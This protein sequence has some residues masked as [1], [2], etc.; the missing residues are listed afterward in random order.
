MHRNCKKENIKVILARTVS[1]H[2]RK[3]IILFF[4]LANLIRWST[5]KRWI[6]VKT[7]SSYLHFRIT[8]KL[9]KT[10][11][12]MKLYLCV[13]HWFTPKV[14]RITMFFFF[15]K[16]RKTFANEANV[17]LSSI[18]KSTLSTVF[19]FALVVFDERWWFSRY[20]LYEL[21]LAKN[22]YPVKLLLPPT[23][24]VFVIISYP[25]KSMPRSVFVI[26][27]LFRTCSTLWQ[28]DW[29]QCKLKI[30]RIV[31][32]LITMSLAVRD[33]PWELFRKRQE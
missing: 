4:M 19:K 10:N 12:A 21:I 7:F 23:G 31:P 1:K 15:F 9:W 13:F 25:Q 8:E 22:N 3:S 14:S 5:V 28:N 27:N 16:E 11:T 24:T 6:R 30:S 17:V 26:G 20:T 18:Q 29:R 32:G 33:F 2:D